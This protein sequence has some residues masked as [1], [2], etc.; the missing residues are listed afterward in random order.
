MLATREVLIDS[1]NSL[2]EV[3]GN[4]LRT[5]D[6]KSMIR[7]PFA[8]PKRLTVSNTVERISARCFAFCDAVSSVAFQG[9]CVISLATIVSHFS[10]LAFLHLKAARGSHCVLEV[11]VIFV[12][13][14]PSFCAASSRLFFS[15]MPLSFKWKVSTVLFECRSELSFTVLASLHFP[16]AHFFH[17][18]AFF[19]LSN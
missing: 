12:Q 2:F 4:F 13:L 10:R 16:S 15:W 9:D 5:R 11:S 1:G 6:S 19:S 7:Y 3:G 8:Y 17:Q 18:F 14:D